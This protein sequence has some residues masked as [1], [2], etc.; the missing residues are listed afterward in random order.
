MCQVEVITNVGRVEQ[1]GFSSSHALIEQSGGKRCKILMGA[2]Q[3]HVR[4]FALIIQIAHPSRAARARW[5]RDR[6]RYVL[7][8]REWL[9]PHSN[10][11]SRNDAGDSGQ[12]RESIKKYELYPKVEWTAQDYTQRCSPCLSRKGTLNEA[13]GRERKFPAQIPQHLSRP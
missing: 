5:I 9:S 3:Q 6:L 7:V 10:L 12:V 11:R 4:V 2:Q 1:K 8:F 13:H